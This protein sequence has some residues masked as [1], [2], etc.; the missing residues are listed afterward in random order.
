MYQLSSRITIVATGNK[1]TTYNIDFVDSI[2]I[3]S[4]W[5]MLFSTANV[6]LP[7]RI[8]VNINNTPFRTSW[9]DANIAKPD[10]SGLGLTQNPTR[11]LFKEGDYIK[12]ELG[13]DAEFTNV[14]EGYIFKISQKVPMELSCV[15]A[16]YILNNIT[17]TST[18]NGNATVDNVITAV[19]NAYE[20]SAI[21][22]QYQTL[23][24]GVY[25]RLKFQGTITPSPILAGYTVTNKTIT[26]V[27]EDLKKLYA[28]DT[29]IQNGTVYCGKPYPDIDRNLAT[30]SN[31]TN[32]FKNPGK[33]VF[34][35]QNN[36]I[37][38]DLVA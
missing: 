24:K 4:S 16:M 19:K 27:F 35:F 14:F 29:F 10:L 13:Y 7:K 5:D 17:M 21:D 11:N 18:F 15:D 22:S 2:S 6:V 23:F 34:G 36:I 30:L 26:Q 28:I 3:S 38:D 8:Y 33:K 37:S 25:N 20:T 9:A 31:L 32:F 1:L 12:I